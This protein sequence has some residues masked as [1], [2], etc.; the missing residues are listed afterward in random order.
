MKLATVNDNGNIKAGMIIGDEFVCCVEGERADM[1]VLSV[2]RTGDVAS[3]DAVIDTAERK[4]LADVQMLA[5][6]PHLIR[7]MVCVGKNYYAHA[8]EFFDSGFDATQKETI[9]SEPIIFTK[10]MTSLIG[11]NDAIDASIDPTDSVDY[12]GELGV[13]ISK[14]ARRVAKADWQDYVFGYVIIND[15]TSR[16]LQKK[17]NQWTIGKGLDTFGPM[18]PYVVTKDEI[19][20]LSSMQIQTLVNDEVRQQAEVRDLIFDIPT[21]IETLTLT[22]TLLAGDVIATGTPVGVGIGFT[23][24]KFLKSGDVVTINVTGLGSLTNPVI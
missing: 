20:D 12:E 9:P 5:P 22:G 3:W 6:I 17:H 7:D 13:I 19:D 1:A 2:I 10:A 16:E 11:P 24:P 23:P 14:T 18:G 15:V 21:L 4:D 8:K